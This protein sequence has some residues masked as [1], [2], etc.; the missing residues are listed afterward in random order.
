MKSGQESVFQGMI[1]LEIHV[2]LTTREKLFCCCRAS[3]EKGLQANVNICPICT[4]MPGA[5]P[6]LPN[7]NAVE[8]AVLVGLMLG[9]KINE[10]LIWQRKH[11][12]WPDLPKGYQNTLSGTHAFPV[13][14]NGKFY[15]IKV[16]SIHLE[17]DPASWEPSSGKV[18]YNRSGLPL[19][20]IITEPDFSSS[21]EVGEWLKKLLHNLEYLKA[22]SS[23]AG[24]K[25]DVNVNIP[26]KTERVEI[27][28]VNSIENIENAI[29]YE[30]ERQ[31]REGS[32]RETRRF[33]EGKGTTVLMREKE[34]ADDY[35]FISDPDLG[36]IVINKKFIS[37]IRERLPESPEVK[38]EKIIKKYKID[39]RNASV[40]ARNLDIAEF[41]EKV[42]ERIDAKFALPWITIELF[43]H[44]NYNKTSLDKIDIKVEHF[45]ELLEMVKS[46]K[47][48]ELQGKQ[49]LNK[50]YPKSF[51]LR[52]VE[53]RID[54]KKELERVCE[55]VLMENKEAV[56]KYRSGDDKVLNFLV[57]EVMRKTNRRA[58]FRVAREV[59]I[60]LLDN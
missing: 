60:R 9:C 21:E 34:S 53:G 42:A 43:R 58:D 15:G 1:G 47:I 38:L 25:V 18:D 31:I 10:R 29:D 48:T 2:Y 30:L 40:L 17:E 20:E 6:M 59:L 4:G 57:G 14:V 23:D 11:Y 32:K 27:K 49:F 35:R 41:F 7:K 52:D 16:R 46:G 39:E 54:D 36:D 51:S 56:Q 8:K 22:V 19:V 45:V 33:D 55:S 26:G 13:G 50:F 5:K 12:N 24:I 44:L 28:N 3:R 37:D